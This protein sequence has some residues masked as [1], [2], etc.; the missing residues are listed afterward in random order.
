MAFQRRIKHF[1]VVLYNIKKIQYESDI[2]EYYAYIIIDNNCILMFKRDWIEQISTCVNM[3][4]VFTHSMRGKN[5]RH[6][7][8][9]CDFFRRMNHDVVVDIEP[10]DTESVLSVVVHPLKT[11]LE[12][13]LSRD[14][15]LGDVIRNLESHVRKIRVRGCGTVVDNV[16]RFTEWALNH[17]WYVEKTFLNTLT[18]K[19]LEHPQ[20]NTAFLVVLRKGSSSPS[21]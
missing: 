14:T 19:S 13:T 18:I 5:K 21:A 1:G 4:K 12:L 11:C 9:A 10:T 6:L 15:A 17:G 2:F 3:G 7:L 16:I 20:K 8:F